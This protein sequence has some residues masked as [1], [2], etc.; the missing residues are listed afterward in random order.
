[1]RSDPIGDSN[2][3]E[4]T[5]S[6][7]RARYHRSHAARKREIRTC[8][9]KRVGRGGTLPGTRG[10]GFALVASIARVL[11]S[12]RVRLR[13][14]AAR[15]RRATSRRRAH[16]G[17]RRTGR[18]RRGGGRHR[19][20]RAGGGAR[21]APGLGLEGADDARAAAQARRRPPLRDAL[22]GERRAAATACSQ[23][24]LVVEGSGDPFFVDE[25]ALLVLLALREP[26]CG[27]SPATSRCAARS[28]STGRR[29]APRRDSSSALAGR[30]SAA[31]WSAVR[32]AERRAATRRARAG[33]RLRRRATRRARPRR[34]CSSTHRSQ[35]LVPLVKALNGYSNNIFAPFARRGGRH[36]ARCEAIARESVPRCA[37]RRDHARRRRRREPRAT[38]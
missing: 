12:R 33:A 31:A 7:A 23:G 13:C 21:G 35:P 8:D 37:A 30:R 20:R 10:G 5:V 22:R 18:L 24:D 11:V 4:C 15:I 36:R 16:A 26:G 2:S 29:R 25:N 3:A 27:A 9:W 34:R 19:A 28:S 6:I 38:G 17:R 1:M 14:I 32:A